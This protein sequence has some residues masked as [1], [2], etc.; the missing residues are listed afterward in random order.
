MFD[1]IEAV[2]KPPVAFTYFCATAQALIMVAA[3]CVGGILRFSSIR[4]I[5]AAP[6]PSLSNWPARRIDCEELHARHVSLIG[7]HG[8]SINKA[9][10]AVIIDRTVVLLTELNDFPALSSSRCL[11][12]VKLQS[13]RDYVSVESYVDCIS[14]MAMWGSNLSGLSRS[15]PSRYQ[16]AR[17]SCES[18]KLA[19]LLTADMMNLSVRGRG[20]T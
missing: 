3:Y 14:L 7:R 19:A 13:C 6:I 2:N 17:N 9:V 1:R 18:K 5:P 8:H 4:S 12:H 20:N 10:L 11:V 16:S 15:A